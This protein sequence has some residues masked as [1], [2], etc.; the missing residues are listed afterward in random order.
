VG[1]T[2]VAIGITIL[3]AIFA[4][5]IVGSAIVVVIA[6]IQDVAEILKHDREEQDTAE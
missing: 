6:G 1:H 2:A 3:E 5:G 4:F